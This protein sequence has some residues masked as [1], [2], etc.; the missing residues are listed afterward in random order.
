MLID[1]AGRF[2]SSEAARQGPVGINMPAAIVRMIN[3]KK[4]D[5]AVFIALPPDSDW[6]EVPMLGRCNRGFR[7]AN[8]NCY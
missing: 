4:A 2:A 6:L 8:M 7:L 5:F 3:G 1:L